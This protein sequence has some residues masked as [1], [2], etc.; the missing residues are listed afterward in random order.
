MD[1]PSKD[2]K[3]HHTGFSKGCRALVANGSCDRWKAI[4]GESRT[5]GLPS[6]MW[7]CI[8]DHAFTLQLNMIAAA[9]GGQAATESFRNE[10]LG[11]S[12]RKQHEPEPAQLEHKDAAE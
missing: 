1:L 5:T 4:H 12:S 3:C 10:V 2:K 8:D 7:A 9:Q 11:R 6:E